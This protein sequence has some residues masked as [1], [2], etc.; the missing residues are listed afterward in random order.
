MLIFISDLHFMDET[1]GEHIGKYCCKKLHVW[2]RTIV[3][4]QKLYY[5]HANWCSYNFIIKKV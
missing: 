2:K 4:C 1:A 3:D 5:V